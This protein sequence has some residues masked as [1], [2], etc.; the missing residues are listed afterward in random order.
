MME[1]GLLIR[2]SDSKVDSIANFNNKL[3]KPITLMELD[4]R[5][6]HQNI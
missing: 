4:L 2:K 1:H 6:Y 5:H 3:L